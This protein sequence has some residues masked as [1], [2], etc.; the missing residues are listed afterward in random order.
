MRHRFYKYAKG[1]GIAL[2]RRFLN[3]R[4]CM[5]GGWDRFHKYAKRSGIGFISMPRGLA[6]LL[7]ECKG[8]CIGNA[9]VS[10]LL[11]EG[12]F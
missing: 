6:L 8:V 2:P 7:V 9:R 3:A 1:S 11:L 5:T 12:G 4:D 10:A